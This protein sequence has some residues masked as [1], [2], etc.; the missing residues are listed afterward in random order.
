MIPRAHPD[1]G[2][3]VT[4]SLTARDLLVLLLQ[5][6]AWLV[7]FLVLIGWVTKAC[8]PSHDRTWLWFGP[9]A[10]EHSMGGLLTATWAV[11]MLVHPWLPRIALAPTRALSLA[12]GLCVL[13]DAC[14]YF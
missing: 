9:W 8:V 14:A 10:Y 2:A 3:T 11:A 7:A 6:C 13:A 5:R 12:V 1:A 4:Q